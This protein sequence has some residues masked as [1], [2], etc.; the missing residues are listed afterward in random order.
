[1]KKYY[2]YEHRTSDGTLFYVG[3][4]TINP[5][6]SYGG[7]QRA[8]SKNNRNSKW[9]EISKNGYIVN[10]IFQSEDLQLILQKENELWENC[11]TCVN[12]QVTKSFKEYQFY[13]IDD[14]YYSLHI[15]KKVYLIHKSGKIINSK[16]NS[17]KCSDNGKDYKIVT[18]SNGE[19][20]KKNMYVHR[21]IAKCFVENPKNLDVVNHKDLNRNNNS[22]ENLEWVT[23]QENIQHSVN[24]SSYVFKDKIKPIYQF[25]KLGQLLKEWDRARSVANFYNCTEELI[26]QACQQKNLKKGIT[27]KGYIWIYKEDFLKNNTKKFDFAKSKYQ[28][29]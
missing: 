27:A 24:L 5:K 1:M 20:L 17:L 4:G 26:Q 3:K 23:Q 15:F 18:F 12:K 2:L 25:N 14:N 29:Y 6:Y 8:Y 19:Y 21:I 28:N 10:I 7:Y 16:G 22:A 9:K 11:S 13:K